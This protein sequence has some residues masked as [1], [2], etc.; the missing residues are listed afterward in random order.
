VGGRLDVPA[1]LRFAVH[2]ADAETRFRPAE[3]SDDD[4]LA[5]DPAHPPGA[6]A[7]VRLLGRAAGSTPVTLSEEERRRL[8]ALGYA[9]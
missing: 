8:E 6:D 7:P 4:V 3:G 1:G 5:L 2:P 9:Q